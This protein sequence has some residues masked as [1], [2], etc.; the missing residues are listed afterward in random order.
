MHECAESHTASLYISNVFYKIINSVR[1]EY[2]VQDNTRKIGNP[3][4]IYESRG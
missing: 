2:N 1:C 4:H 3:K